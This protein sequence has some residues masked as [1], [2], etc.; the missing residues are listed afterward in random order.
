MKGP[1][2]VLART[3]INPNNRRTKT[4]GISHHFFSCTRNCTNSP[5][6]PG[7]L[8]FASCSNSSTCSSRSRGDASWVIASDSRQAELSELPEVIIQALVGFS[9][10]PVRF[11]TGVV[12]PFQ[13]V[14]PDCPH[15]YPRRCHH[16]IVNCRQEQPGQHKTDRESRVCHAQVENPHEA[17]RPS[18]DCRNEYRRCPRRNRRRRPVMLERGDADDRE[19][20]E[21]DDAKNRKLAPRRVGT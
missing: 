7:S 18:S 10:N 15:E 17:R 2:P 11:S 12:E 14:M 21:P 19:E 4:I 8:R 1:A 13:R 5:A 20:H 9:R 3:T 16:K 6:M